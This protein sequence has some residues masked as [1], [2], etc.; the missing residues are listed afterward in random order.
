[1][2]RGAAFDLYGWYTHEKSLCYKIFIPCL[3]PGRHSALLNS[4]SAAAS[5][6]RQLSWTWLSPEAPFWRGAHRGGPQ[7]CLGEIQSG[8]GCRECTVC[9]CREC[10]VCSVKYYLCNVVCVILFMVLVKCRQNVTNKVFITCVFNPVYPHTCNKLTA[11]SCLLRLLN[12]LIC[13]KEV[14]AS[15]FSL[16]RYRIYI[17]YCC[18]RCW[19]SWKRW[20][21]STSSK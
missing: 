2:E 21:C 12:A 10:T 16:W 4:G 20:L 14:E 6:D 13:L 9:G 8:H 7:G 18:S 3:S 1:M 19:S 11:L 15:S 5:V 17:Q